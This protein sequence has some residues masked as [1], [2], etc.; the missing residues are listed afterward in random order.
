M[1]PRLG[2]LLILPIAPR[3]GHPARR[4]IIRGTRDSRASLKLLP[5]L[6]LHDGQGYQPVVEA[7]LRTGAALL[8]E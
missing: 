5:P 1:Q 2:Q 7:V 8:L 3:P 4:V 6:I